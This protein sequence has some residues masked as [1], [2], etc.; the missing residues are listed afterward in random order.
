ME[1]LEAFLNHTEDLLTLSHRNCPSCCRYTSS[2]A[3][4]LHSDVPLEAADP[5][6]DAIHHYVAMRPFEWFLIGASSSARR[7]LNDVVG[8]VTSSE[9]GLVT[10]GGRMALC[11][12]RTALMAMSVCPSGSLQGILPFLYDDCLSPLMKMLSFAEQPHILVCFRR[13][14]VVVANVHLLAPNHSISVLSSGW[15]LELLES[16]LS[17]DVD[18]V[19]LEAALSISV[20]HHLVASDGEKS[21]RLGDLLVGPLKANPAPFSSVVVSLVNERFSFVSGWLLPLLPRGSAFF[22]SDLRILVEVLRREGDCPSSPG[23]ASAAG[24]NHDSF[25]HRLLQSSAPC[26]GSRVADVVS[27][28]ALC[29]LQGGDY[30]ETIEVNAIDGEAFVALTE[31]DFRELGFVAEDRARLALIMN[32]ALM[33][34]QS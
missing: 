22:P 26:S 24:G 10:L 23:R 5:S 15:A 16:L 4:L 11:I 19:P 12:M 6:A 30:R 17:Y 3:A 2:V 27:W 8:E 13:F 29:G 1:Q 25:I 31:S 9:D 18:G 20:L 32:P 7:R 28:L 34:P 33:P 14:L 21:I